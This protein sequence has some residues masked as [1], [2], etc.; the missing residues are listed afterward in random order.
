MPG[1]RFARNLPTG[2]SAPSGL[3]SS[4]R[5]SPTWSETASTPWSTS[6]GANGPANEQVRTLT[7]E[8]AHAH[9]VGYEQYGR[10]QAEVLVDCVT[11]CVLGSMGLDVGGESIPYVA[12]WGED[13]A[14]DAIR[15][16]AHTIDTI[17]RRIE[18][19]LE[20]TPEPGAEAVE[21]EVLAAQPRSVGRGSIES[22]A[23][24]QSSDANSGQQTPASAWPPMSAASVPR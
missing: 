17:A 7:H 5:L 13:G 6:C 19:A 9:G 18:H 10:E 15:D 20:P 3:S 24:D 2:V 14:L 8:I 22:P 16:Y 23:V 12:G 21:P 1:P 11:Y 4:T